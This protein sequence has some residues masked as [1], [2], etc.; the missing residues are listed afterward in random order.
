MVKIWNEAYWKKEP[1]EAKQ[2]GAVNPSTTIA[3][4][5]LAVAVILLGVFA[6]PVVEVCL[7]AGEQIVN[8]EMYI[9]AVLGR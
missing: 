7:Q 8:P 3:T 4:A 1:A 2:P 9:N 5:L 6:G